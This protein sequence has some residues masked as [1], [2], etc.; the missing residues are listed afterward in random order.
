MA[1]SPFGMPGLQLGEGNTVSFPGLDGSTDSPSNDW[2]FSNGYNNPYDNGG[3][4]FLSDLFTGDDRA[5]YDKAYDQWLADTQYQRMVEDMK[6]A[7][8]NPY[9]LM[10]N[11]FG[12]PGNYAYQSS[13]KEGSKDSLKQLLMAV[14]MIAGFFGG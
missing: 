4:N 10:Q 7:G 5:R 11:G 1:I 2:D 8:L 3:W 12:S 13:S 14:A 9:L 6:K